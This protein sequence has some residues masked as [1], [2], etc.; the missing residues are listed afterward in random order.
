[1]CAMHASGTPARPQVVVI[2]AGM[3]GLATV[4]ALAHAPVTVQLID[5]HNYTLFPPLLFQVATCFISSAEVARPIR[6]RTGPGIVVPGRRQLLRQDPDRWARGHDAGAS[7]AARRRSPRPAPGRPAG[8]GAHQCTRTSLNQVVRAGRRIR[9]LR[10][11]LAEMKEAAHAHDTKVND[12]VLDLWSGGLR[13]LLL[14]PPGPRYRG[15]LSPTRPI[16][17]PPT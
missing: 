12:V 17:T 5:A 10:L 2:G 11:D 4:R 8:P 16:S 13:Q 1:M 6:T 15:W 7:A 9:F 14:W 3:A